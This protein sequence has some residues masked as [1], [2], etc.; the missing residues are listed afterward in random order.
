[1]KDLRSQWTL[2]PEV[3]FLNHGSFG[4]CPRVVLEHQAALRAEIEREPVRFLSREIERRLDAVRAELGPFLGAAGEDL[5]FVPNATTGVNAVL[6][7]LAFEF[8]VRRH[9]YNPDWEEREWG[10]GY[11][12]FQSI[13]NRLAS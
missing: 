9:H 1:M 13:F 10:W 6:R 11:Y 3:A 8:M 12:M 2:D 5:A 4:A 7:S